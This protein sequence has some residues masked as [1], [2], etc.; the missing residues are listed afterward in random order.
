MI[1]LSLNN[2]LRIVFRVQVLYTIAVSLHRTF[3]SKKCKERNDMIIRT[4][5]RIR[6]LR[7]KKNVTQ[8]QLAVFLGVTPQ[9]VSRWENGGG[10]PD[11]EYLPM[12]ADFFGVTT[13]D[14]LGIHPDTRA[15]RL[16]EIYAQIEYTSK[17]KEASEDTIAY[18]RAAAAEFPAEERLQDALA[19]EICKVYMWEE[20]PNR[21]KLYEAEKIYK[22]LIETTRDND[23]RC[24]VLESLCSLYA[25]G[26]RDI[27]K[28]TATA[29]MLSSMKYTRESVLANVLGNFD[30]RY[31]QEYIV[32]L[33][34]ELGHAMEWSVTSENAPNSPDT[35]EA[36][37][38]ALDTIL[39]LYDAMFGGDLNY[40]HEHAAKICRLKATYLVAMGRY[41][42]ALDELGAMLSH[43]LECDALQ[44]G[45]PFTSY[46][47]S[48]LTF[49]KCDDAL[50][51]AAISGEGFDW[52]IGHNL[53]YW[54]L[55][56][57]EQACYDP[58][59][60]DEHFQ[61]ILARMKERAR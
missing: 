45:Y 23:L 32:R 53:A 14:I 50:P 35:W 24:G 20:S 55:Q 52:Y 57:M 39:A 29:E 47:A 58:F 1:L 8:E 3:E 54:N 22:T 56:S 37:L 4:G 30:N 12:L 5:E 15:Q 34:W 28:A 6:Q 46:F 51:G 16:R 61:S 40:F 43:T 41:D 21:T 31:R 7:A 17:N 48:E 9:A 36:K 10:Y 26:Y 49:P 44:P 2:K 11:I 60:G 42:K 13:D 27:D 38:A 18:I 33:V 25:H 19:C 59:R